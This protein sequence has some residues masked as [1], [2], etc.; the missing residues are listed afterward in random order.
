MFGIY[1]FGIYSYFTYVQHISYTRFKI[2]LAARLYSHTSF[3]GSLEQHC[4]LN[5]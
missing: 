4:G 5:F 1:E 3:R 2:V